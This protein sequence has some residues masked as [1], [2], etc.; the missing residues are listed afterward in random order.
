MEHI[1]RYDAWKT[2]PPDDYIG[3]CVSCGCTVY[4]GSGI[5]DSRGHVW[6]NDCIRDYRSNEIMKDRRRKLSREYAEV[7]KGDIIRD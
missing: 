4:A 2:T 5:S 7:E 1:P 6:C 3:S